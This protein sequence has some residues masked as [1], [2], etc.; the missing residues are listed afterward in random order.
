MIEDKFYTF[1]VNQ[2]EEEELS[3][4]EEDLK[5]EDDEWSEDVE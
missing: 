5:E 2:D 3:E 4:P 1:P